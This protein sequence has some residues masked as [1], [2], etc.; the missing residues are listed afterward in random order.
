M[1]EMFGNLMLVRIFFFGLLGC[2]V[3]LGVL[4]NLMIFVSGSWLII[5][6]FSELV[7]VLLFCEK[8]EYVVLNFEYFILFCVVLMMVSDVILLSMIILVLGNC[9]LNVVKFVD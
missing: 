8:L 1:F 4:L 2:F 3:L 9:W 7:L 6:I 5:L